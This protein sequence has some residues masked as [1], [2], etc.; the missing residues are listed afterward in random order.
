MNTLSSYKKTWTE[1]A[2]WVNHGA[3]ETTVLVDQWQQKYNI[4]GNLGEIGV[5]QAKFFC[6]LSLLK[7]ENECC[8][9]FDLFEGYMNNN[10]EKPKKNVEKYGNVDNSCLIIQDSKTLEL[11]G[12]YRI[13]HIDGDHTHEMVK[14]DIEK[15]I[16]NMHED[17]IMIIDDF[18]HPEF[19]GCTEVAFEYMQQGKLFPVAFGANKGWFSLRPQNGLVDYIHTNIKSALNKPIN[20]LHG[21]RCV[22]ML[23]N[24]WKERPWNG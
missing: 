14:N 11:V 7:R 17:G 10:I 19:P 1:I 9:G 16:Y 13:F 22:G 12:E 15:V 18:F 23:F 4:K 2:G 5:Y 21:T 8:Y 24:E 6:L 3:I 20:T